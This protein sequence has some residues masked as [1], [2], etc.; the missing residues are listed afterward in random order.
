M[1]ITLAWLK[2]VNA[3]EDG[4]TWFETNYGKSA[5]L[6][7]LCRRLLKENRF[8]WADWVLT[9]KMK[10]IQLIDYAIYSASLVLPIFEKE[11]PN[12][13]RPR[14]AIEAA[15]TYLKTHSAR[16]ADRAAEMLKTKL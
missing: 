14:Q 8:V 5:E 3:C 15:K 13:A 4:V 2:K 16:N 11:Y 12:D 7:P 1:I 9:A 10:R 6:K